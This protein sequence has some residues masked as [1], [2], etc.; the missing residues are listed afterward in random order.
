MAIAW[1]FLYI[2]LFFQNKK[3]YTAIFKRLPWMAKDDGKLCGIF[4][5]IED[6]SI[7]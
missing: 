1:A 5:P 7:A 3:H 2:H 4:G 6:M